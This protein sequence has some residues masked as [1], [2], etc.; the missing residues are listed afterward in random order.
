MPATP[1]EL[2]QQLKQLLPEYLSERCRVA[3]PGR[4]AE[5][6]GILY[7]MCTAVRAEENPAL[8]TAILLSR[9]T[10]RPLLVYHALS[11]QYPFASDR[12]HTFILEAARDV[13]QQLLTRGI[14]YVFH[15]ERPGSRGDHLKTLADQAALVITEDMPVAPPASFLAG[16]ASRTETAIIA[17]DTACICPMQLVGRACDRAFQFRDA[18]SRFHR[19][20]LLRPWPLL[21][22]R[23]AAW[24]PQVLP[25]RP[26]DLSSASIPDLV[27]S[28]RIDHAVGPVLDTQGGT[29]AGMARWNAF[30]Q[31]GLRHYADRRNNPLED[32]VSRMSAWL[33]Y[34]MVSPLR[35]AREA[36]ELKHDG[37]RKYLDELLIWRELAWCFCRYRPDYGDWSAIPRWAQQTLLQHAGDPRPALYTWEQLAA[38]ETNDPLWNAAQK[39]LR[40]HGELHNNVRM[41]WGKALLQWTA[42]PRRALKLIIDL[43]HRY[44]LDGR[45]P[46]SYGGILW[47]L[48]QFDRPF[49]PEQPVLGTVR[50][51]PTSEHARRL[52]P[53]VWS[54]RTSVTR[55]NPVPRIA[56]IGGG[57]SGAA[58][59]RTL[60]DHAL[61]V[62]VFDKSRGA[63]GR[64][65]GRR[66]GDYR[67]DH[68]AAAFHARDEAFRRVTRSWVEAGVAGVWDGPWM[69]VD[70]DGTWREDP[71]RRQLAAIPGMTAAARHL[72]QGIP[73]ESGRRIVR[74]EQSDTGW[75][76]YDEAGVAAGPFDQVILA[77]PAPQTADLLAASQP[78][79]AAIIQQLPY[80]VIRTLMAGFAAPLEDIRWSVAVAA[81]PI[82][83]RIIRSQTRP[84]GGNEQPEP[85][86]C[87][88]LHSTAEWGGTHAETDADSVCRALLD[89]FQRLLGRPLP[90]PDVTE[91]HRWKF[92]EPLQV[93]SSFRQPEAAALVQDL[94][95]VGIGLCGDWLVSEEPGCCGVETAWQSGVNA[96][97]RVLRGLRREIRVQRALW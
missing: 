83:G 91:V 71:S 41:T 55:A 49:T 6:G 60:A 2:A 62:T 66:V 58:A 32:G 9:E 22:E 96:A 56:I 29:A 14:P 47:C 11:E 53:G 25:F 39:S 54:R 57:I 84:R 75:V 16:L 38:G 28:C 61:P 33:H 65:A 81:G 63:G 13:Q 69:Q 5:T 23:P 43:N 88:V 8:D 1:T 37:A 21:T 18:V 70:A 93:L 42:D 48:G 85:R 20:R 24:E 7:W 68:G 74:L 27:G 76:L 97:G 40:I 95:G 10:R 34:G 46:A 45:D 36:A 80:A 30:R 35:I 51:R 67:F 15:L 64:M 3:H 59:A 86:E 31:Q 12:H 26:V 87:L 94:H 72:L 17:V 19:E 4:F 52:D 44:A 89:E 73:L 78:A 92:A 50:P 79:A 82:L 77:L 90:R